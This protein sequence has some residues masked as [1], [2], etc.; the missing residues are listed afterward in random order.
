MRYRNASL[1]L[2]WL[3]GPAAQA[4]PR[5]EHVV[6]KKYTVLVVYM[7]PNLGTRF[8][9]PFVLD[10][11]NQYVPFTLTLTNKH[12][13]EKREPGRNSFVLTAAP[14]A[15]DADLFITAAGYEITIELHETPSLAR[16]YSDIIFDL[17]PGARETLI[18]E[19]VAQRTQALEQEYQQK[20][21]TL[22]HM[23]Q[24]RALALVGVLALSH[25]SSERIRQRGVTR[26]AD[27]SALR[28]DVARAYHYGP[29]T[30][31][32]FRMRNG[33]DQALTV[34]Q[35]SLLQRDPTTHVAVAVSGGS[36]V[37]PHLG[38]QSSTRGTVTVFTRDLNP[39]FTTELQVV[40][41]RGRVQAQW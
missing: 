4:F 39:R 32:R 33:A 37:A 21:A 10:E 29:Y 14:A 40:T 26:L 6:L 34:R 17:G 3:L 5:Q 38:A 36:H 22:D 13:I 41:D 35:A 30:I 15:G 31:V 1:L 27:G 19:A 20:F 7:T 8:L 18:Q 11:Q 9:F 12:F 28:L 2:L 25:P 16:H 24:S 23:A